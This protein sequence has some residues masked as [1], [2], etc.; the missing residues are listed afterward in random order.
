MLES[1]T[2]PVISR[3]RL[4][5]KSGP[6]RDIMVPWQPPDPFGCAPTLWWR[7]GLHGRLVFEISNHIFIIIRWKSSR[8]QLFEHKSAPVCQQLSCDT[9]AVPR[10]TPI[11]NVAAYTIRTLSMKNVNFFHGAFSQSRRQENTA[12][13][14][15]SCNAKCLVEQRGVRSERVRWR[16]LPREAT[17]ICSSC[18]IGYWLEYTSIHINW[19]YWL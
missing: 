16:W 17:W 19:W 11:T 10:Y 6:T 9:Y 14:T 5:G 13:F 18:S 12:R 4:M 1:P 2:V 15:I 8:A 7:F 3:I